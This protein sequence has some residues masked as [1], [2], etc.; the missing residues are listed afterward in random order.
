MVLSLNLEF[1][2]QEHNDRYR[3]R[4][5]Y[6][7]AVAGFAL[8][9]SLV[10]S[11]AAD[12]SSP[13]NS[14]IENGSGRAIEERGDPPDYSNIID[15]VEA[16]ADNSGGR[17]I[18][19]ILN[20]VAD[21]STLIRFPEGTY[22]IDDQFRIADYDKFGI[23]GEN[24]T[25]RVAPTNGYVFKL[26]TYQSPINELQIDGLTFDIS[27]DGT[28]GRVLELQASNNL[29]AHEIDIVGTHDTANKGPL[30]VG[31][32]SKNGTGII[33]NIDI[34]DGGIDTDHGNGG[35]GLLVSNHHQGT[36][37][38]RDVHI[39]PFPDNGLYVSGADGSV[40]V[41]G[42]IF[43]NANVAGVRLKG[44]GSTIEGAQFIV[45]E[46]FEGFGAQRP[47]RLDNGADVEV[48]NCEI[49]M[50]APVTE[51]LRILPDVESA[52]IADVTMELSDQVRDGIAVTEG[53]GPVTVDD[54]EISG[55]SRYKVYEY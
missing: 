12:E 18:N 35:T 34:S 5:L 52:V 53:A 15:I 1:R 6:C 7:K 25:I 54:L 43:E 33:E 51:A 38:I 27:R 14:S 46:S 31:L 32:Q 2:M 30:L 16:G 45:D 55:N 37:T 9:T 50:D 47:I 21:D 17:S 44:D 11:A 8:S 48:R 10:P 29:E 3:S 41:E 40:H 13:N 36:I 22:L 4:R 23:T 20:E 24:A 39:G 26:G 42:G 19:P 49:E 28:G